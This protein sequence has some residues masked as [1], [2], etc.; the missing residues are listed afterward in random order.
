MSP[1]K[2]NTPT[3]HIIQVKLTSIVFTILF[4]NHCDVTAWPNKREER[5]H[6]T[7]ERKLKEMI[8]SFL[9]LEWFFPSV[10]II[11]LYTRGHG[12]TEEV[13]KSFMSLKTILFTYYLQLNWKWL[14]ALSLLII[15]ILQHIT[16]KMYLFLFSLALFWTV[17]SEELHCAY[18]EVS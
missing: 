18:T 2:L 11:L 16:V 8:Q 5:D 7:P 13:W 1:T 17:K 9:I 4:N 10:T 12:I 15:N 14:S 3:N 6:N